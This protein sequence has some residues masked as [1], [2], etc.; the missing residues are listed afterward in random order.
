M[1]PDLRSGWLIKNEFSSMITTCYLKS[2]LIFYKQ[3]KIKKNAL[4][5]SEIEG[6]GCGDASQFCKQNQ[7]DSLS[8]RRLWEMYPDDRPGL[9]MVRCLRARSYSGGAPNSKTE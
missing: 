8:N 9:C 4:K 1:P 6:H 3:K 2:H 7:I 5:I